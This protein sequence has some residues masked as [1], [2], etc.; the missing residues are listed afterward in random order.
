MSA[1]QVAEP[2]N[3][4]R[5]EATWQWLCQAVD[6]IGRPGPGLSFPLVPSSADGPGPAHCSVLA[7]PPIA[8]SAHMARDFT[9]TTLVDRTTDERVE[10]VAVTVSELLS[11][12]LR[13]GRAADGEA[14]LQPAL[15]LAYWDRW[16]CAV[17]AVTDESDLIPVAVQA[18]EL[19][20]SGRGLQ[21]VSVLSDAWGWNPRAGG[22]KL[23]WALFRL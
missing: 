7:V 20:E 10:D 22:G 2:V 3:P 8:Q 4:L 11:N 16:S 21:V 18:D 19:A 17:C 12:A 1:E 9:R 5:I 14:E 13:Y 6:H 23:V 15:W